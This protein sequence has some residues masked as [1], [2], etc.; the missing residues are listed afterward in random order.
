M[1]RNDVAAFADKLHD[2][3]SNCKNSKPG[4]GPDGCQLPECWFFPIRLLKERVKNE[5][6]GLDRILKYRLTT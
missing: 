6:R 2:H 4:W 3:C 1:D 5:D